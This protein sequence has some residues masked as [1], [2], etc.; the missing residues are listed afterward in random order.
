[1]DIQFV[2]PSETPVPPEDM[3]IQDLSVE[4]S[5]DGG[6]IR[7]AVDI[8]P[9]LEP[10]SLQVAVRDHDGSEIA[11][12]AVIGLVTAHLELTLH[13]RGESDPEDLHVEVELGYPPDGP[14]DRRRVPLVE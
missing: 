10:P 6:R 4:R 1:M 9:F 13:L 11:S 14:V 5:R 12:A 3:R 2:E 7:L 8:T